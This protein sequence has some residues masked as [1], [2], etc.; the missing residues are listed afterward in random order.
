MNFKGIAY[1]TIWVEYPDIAPKMKEIG[2]KPTDK[3]DNGDDHYTLPVIQ[4]PNTGAIVSDSFAIAEYLEKT[5]PD[6]PKLFPVGSEGLQAAFHEAHDN[7]IAVPRLIVKLVFGILNPESQGYFRETR[8]AKGRKIEAFDEQSELQWERAEAGY[9]KLA[10]W[11]DKNGP[12]PFI[13]GDSL[14]YGDIDVAGYFTWYGNVTNRESEE[15]K[16]MLTWD[17]GRWGKLVDAV[18]P[19]ESVEH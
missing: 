19:Y 15:W 18:K 11:Y 16:K 3:K 9:S 10:A 2:A 12:G 7:G 17:G 8:E 1:Q 14:T 4:D 13:Q 6:T 5:Y